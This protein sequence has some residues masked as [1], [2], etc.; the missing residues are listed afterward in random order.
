MRGRCKT[1]KYSYFM[2][3][4]SHLGFLFR[5][6]W[7]RMGVDERFWSL[8]V[9]WRSVELSLVGGYMW[10]DDIALLIKPISFHPKEIR[11]WK[12]AF[13]GAQFFV[14][15]LWFRAG[16]RRTTVEKWPSRRDPLGSPFGDLVRVWRLA[17]FLCDHHHVCGF[18]WLLLA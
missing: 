5:M 6:R 17:V 14:L 4:M 10:C 13:L 3:Y 7:Y 16:G 2:F 12:C 1:L 15:S 8:I 18:S 11:W 9:V